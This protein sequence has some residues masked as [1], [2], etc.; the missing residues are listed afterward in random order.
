MAGFGDAL[1]GLGEGFAGRGGEWQKQ[2]AL[3]A[4]GEQLQ[5][6]QIDQQQY[7]Q[8]LAQTDPMAARE[9]AG[10]NTPSALREFA[11]LQNMSQPEKDLYFQNKR[12]QQIVNLG[13]TQGIIP[14]QGGAPTIQ[15]PVT[16]RPEDQPVNAAAKRGAEAAAVSNAESL[17]E[18]KNVMTKMTPLVASLDKLK[19]S[20][21]SAPSGVG[22]AT[23]AFIASKTVGGEGAKSYGTFKTDRASAENEI[24]Q[25]F[26]VVGSG[27]TS[28]R[29]AKPFIEML[30][31]ADDTADVKIVKTEAALAA[32]KN[33]VE[34]LA[35]AKNLP[36]P[37]Q[38]A[39]PS[40]AQTAP[41][42]VRYNA[43]GQ[44]ATLVNGKW[45]I[46]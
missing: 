13:G 11:A 4:L 26:R 35:K 29:D 10:V 3:K 17:S 5:S 24:R 36:N 38:E 32:V 2:Y 45:V 16:L 40:P 30:P 8:A 9:V 41:S 28:D 14:A 37:F 31:E 18:A 27:A 43:K 12:A 19:E 42:N 1:V 20:S 33:K 22:G 15:L 23:T 46:E 6:G 21:L 39:A 44:K 7:L 34:A 25:A